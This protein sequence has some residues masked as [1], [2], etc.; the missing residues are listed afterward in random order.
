MNKVQWFS[1]KLHCDY[2]RPSFRRLFNAV[3]FSLRPVLMLI[4][5]DG[6]AWKSICPHCGSRNVYEGGNS[7]LRCDDCN[8][9]I[10]W[11]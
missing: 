4:E 8:H 7:Y 1:V 3:R 5:P 10:G 9:G 11:N 2:K 6:N